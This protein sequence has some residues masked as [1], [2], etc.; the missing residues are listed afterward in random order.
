MLFKQKSLN[1]SS[2]AISEEKIKKFLNVVSV[3]SRSLIVEF[4]YV[5][6]VNCSIG[7]TLFSDIRVLFSS[8]NF[9]LFRFEICQLDFHNLGKHVKMNDNVLESLFDTSCR[10]T[11]VCCLC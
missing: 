3:F 7:I 8:L 11:L 2:P 10:R 1:C 5:E 6:F 9:C 4:R